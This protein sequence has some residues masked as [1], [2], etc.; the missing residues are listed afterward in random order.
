MLTLSQERALDVFTQTQRNIYIRGDAGVGKTF[1]LKKMQE[2]LNE[3]KKKHLT[4]AQTGSAAA[5]AGGRTVARAFIGSPGIR[6]P[7]GWLA[8]RADLDRSLRDD[9]VLR[10]FIKEAD[11]TVKEDCML[12]ELDVLF[13]DEVSL[14]CSGTLALVDHRLRIQRGCPRPFG[15]IRVIVT[16]D[17]GQLPPLPPRLG[18]AETG[19]TGMPCFHSYTPDGEEDA[20][21]LTPWQDARLVPVTLHEQV[22]ALG[23]PFFG[24]I[25]KAMR[26]GQRLSQWQE[27]IR[28]ALM[29]RYFDRTP[30]G[31]EDCTH[32]F[33]GNDAVQKHNAQKNNAL[34]G[35]SLVSAEVSRSVAVFNCGE[36]LMGGASKEDSVLLWKKVEALYS[37]VPW[38]ADALQIKVGTKVMFTK[39]VDVDAGVTNGATGVVTGRGKRSADDVRAV[40][41]RGDK[42]GYQNVHPLPRRSA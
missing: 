10:K 13:L 17:F 35:S 27:D 23:D 20:L 2:I 11:G 32:C 15:G 3:N 40:Q 24:R 6:S 41:R 31:M 21:Q 5:V 14:F 16:G 18:R 33:F 38:A 29:S 42:E 12:E 39:N 19:S 9:R 8:C 36:R 34:V 25:A 7:R 22:R 37:E 4:L 28:A 26:S 1:L 30:P